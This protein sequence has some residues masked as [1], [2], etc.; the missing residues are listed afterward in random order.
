[1]RIFDTPMGRLTAILGVCLVCTGLWSL[2]DTLTLE[3]SITVFLTG[4]EMG[5]LKPC[6]CSGG[7][8]GGLERRS[9]ILD[10]VPEDQRLLIS[11]GSQIADT[12]EQDL[13]KYPIFIQA[14]SL[15]GYDV[16]NMTPEDRVAADLT[17]AWEQ[18]GA[19]GAVISQ[20]ADGEHGLENRFVKTFDLGGREVRVRVLSI[21]A[22]ESLAALTDPGDGAAQVTVFIL[23]REDQD[24]LEQVAAMAGP[25][26]CIV[27]PDQLD[28]PKAYRFEDADSGPLVVC[29][30][31]HGRYV[32]RLTITLDRQIGLPHLGFEGLAVSEDLANNP[33]LE[34]LYRYYQGIVRSSGLMERFSR[35][36]LP[37]GLSYLGS[38]SCKACHPGEY[39][40]WSR[41]KHSQAW[42]TLVDVGSDQDPECVVCHVVGME[43]EQGFLTLQDTAYLKDVG[44]ET[45]HGPGSEH[46]RTLG[47]AMTCE[48]KKTCLDCH[49]PEH[50]GGYAGHEDEYL[51]KIRHWREPKGVGNVKE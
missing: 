39:G 48:P 35:V 3:D 38:E 16:I 5:S 37:S 4:R 47:R 12:T 29:L 51:E 23:N 45:C 43:Y 41:E 24:L 11:T 2:G 46:N 20:E 1:M 22:V 10:A 36:P 44:C 14:L 40:Q 31:L 25:G 34:D 17:G 26:D 19:F 33:A 8:L 27:Y 42:K 49:T 15:L 32:G 21:G 30:G 9:A 6:G 13:I 7:Q 28:T 50:S 18:L